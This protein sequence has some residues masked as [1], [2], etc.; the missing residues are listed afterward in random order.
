MSTENSS[1]FKSGL[2][3]IPSRSYRGDRSR[4]DDNLLFFYYC[5][6]FKEIYWMQLLF[7]MC[8]YPAVYRVLRY[9][10]ELVFQG[11][12]VDS[13]C[14]EENLDR[15]IELAREL[16]EEKYGWKLINSVLRDLGV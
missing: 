12:H 8:N 1:T 9:V 14:S 6:V 3:F 16:E 15:R 4:L 2:S 5:M 10:W 13:Q 11:Y 7:L